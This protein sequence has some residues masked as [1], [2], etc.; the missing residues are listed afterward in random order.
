MWLAD[1]PTELIYHLF[2][3]LNAEDILLSFRLVSRRFYLLAESHDRLRIELTHLT[4][5]SNAGRLCRL[6]QPSSVISLDWNE[7]AFDRNKVT[8]CFV[9]SARLDQFHQLRSMTLRNMNE[10]SVRMLISPLIGVSMLSSVIIGTNYFTIWRD[11]KTISVLSSLIALDS[12]RQLTLDIYHQAIDKLI[13]PDQSS[14]EELTLRSCTYR[15]FCEI[16]DR[17]PS[18]HTFV[19]NE[20]SMSDIDQRVRPTTDRSLTSLTL[21]KIALPMTDLEFFLSLHP[22]LI[23]LTLTTKQDVSWEHLKH[24]TGWGT[25]LCSILPHLQKLNLSV[26]STTPKFRNVES[27]LSPLCSTF[28]LEEKQWFFTCQCTEAFNFKQVQLSSFTSSS[29]SFPDVLDCADISYAITTRRANNSTRMWSARIDLTR[30]INT[31]IEKKADR[32]NARPDPY[33]VP[34]QHQLTQLAFDI[35]DDPT[36][37]IESLQRISTWLNLAQLEELWIMETSPHELQFEA[38]EYLLE[39]ASQLRTFGITCDYS[40]SRLANLGSI[41]SGRIDHLTVRGV[42]L[43]CVKATLEHI[44]HVPVITFERLTHGSP[45]YESIIDYLTLEQTKFTVNYEAASI[46][47]QSDSF[48][49]NG[50]LKRKRDKDSPCPSISRRNIDD[51]L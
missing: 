27:I 32:S 44:H 21:K 1:L 30:L 14:L 20:S 48:V 19:V 28:W 33:I 2:R 50:R 38:I 34:D 31:I 42:D 24:F 8:E 7:F 37:S 25:F 39:Q 43:R 45:I 51:L 4:S 9:R 5:S 47:I 46:R 29:P 12:L 10:Q 22:R 23:S 17:S 15:Q 3:F 13:W 41:I 40:P 18:L 26:S 36:L 16:F 49:T 35:D 11:E 6:L